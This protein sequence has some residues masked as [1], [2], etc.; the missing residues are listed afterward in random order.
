M[1]CA[2]SNAFSLS[3]QLQV[4]L[5]LVLCLEHKKFVVYHTVLEKADEKKDPLF[6]RK[7]KR[8]LS[9]SK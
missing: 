6:D 7:Q 2:L 3:N 9:S 1:E 4:T 5:A 8:I